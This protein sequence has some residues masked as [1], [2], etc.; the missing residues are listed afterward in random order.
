[1]FEVVYSALY[2]DEKKKRSLKYINCSER[3]KV[4]KKTGEQ[5]TLSLKTIEDYIVYYLKKKEFTIQCVQVTSLANNV[6]I[7]LHLDGKLLLDNEK[8]LNSIKTIKD[9]FEEVFEDGI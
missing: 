1:M 9:I 8:L 6:M 5:L 4:I 7:I 3:G 2:L